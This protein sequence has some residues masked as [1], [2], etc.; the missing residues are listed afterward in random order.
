MVVEADGRWYVGPDNGLFSRV[1]AAD[2]ATRCWRI[3]W[4]PAELSHTFHGRDLFAPVAARLA[5]GE[6]PPGALF[7][8]AYSLNC[9]WPADH[10]AVIYIDHFGNAMT[11]IRAT[12]LN[13]DAVLDV[14]G[15]SFAYARTFADVAVGQGFWYR[16]ANG[17]IEIAINQGHAADHYKLGP[18]VPVTIR[19]GN[20]PA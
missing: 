11:G 17:L 14:A 10:P 4:R 8:Q 7:P 5:S 3:D 6:A 15:E 19:K 12:A 2:P 13:D 9:G 18:G 16:N 20:K 1:A